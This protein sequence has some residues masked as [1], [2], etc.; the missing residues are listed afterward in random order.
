MADVIKFGPHKVEVRYS[1]TGSYS[2]WY[3]EKHEKDPNWGS[4]FCTADVAFFMRVDNK[5]I[6]KI[7]SSSGDMFHELYDI[8]NNYDFYPAEMEQK[9][10]DILLSNKVKL[11]EPL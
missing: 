7:Q 6:Y 1:E 8:A 10:K 11:Q 5:D 4:G 2:P 9:F 3:R